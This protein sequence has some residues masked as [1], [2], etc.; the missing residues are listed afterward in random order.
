MGELWLGSRQQKDVCSLSSFV[1]NITVTDPR[2]AGAGP[3][4]SRCSV[5]G[6]LGGVCSLG[7][8]L[9]EARSAGRNGAVALAPRGASCRLGR[10]GEGPDE[11]PSSPERAPDECGGRE[12]QDEVQHHG[13]DGDRKGGDAGLEQ[14]QRPVV[15][16]DVDVRQDDGPPPSVLGSLD[17][18][19]K[20]PLSRGKVNIPASDIVTMSGPSRW[21]RRGSRFR[22]AFVNKR[23][24]PAPPSTAQA[25]PGAPRPPSAANSWR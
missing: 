6:R 14:D 10:L 9:C 15:E 13:D 5:P 19:G 1:C 8:G 4:R 18:S 23:T 21:S 7:A 17:L 24:L 12:G 11:P 25:R 20:V 3:C 2:P 16:P 22:A